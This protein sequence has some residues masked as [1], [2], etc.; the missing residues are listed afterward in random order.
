MPHSNSIKAMLC[1]DGVSQRCFGKSTGAGTAATRDP[2]L[3]IVITPPSSN[4]CHRIK[5]QQKA[6]IH[7]SLVVVVAADQ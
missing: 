4:C 5:R 7:G 1:S 2:S 3:V 6:I